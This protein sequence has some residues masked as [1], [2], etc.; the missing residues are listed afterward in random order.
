MTAVIAVRCRSTLPAATY[1][2]ASRCTRVVAGVHRAASN[3]AVADEHD[4]TD[5]GTGAYLSMDKARSLPSD[6]QVS[7]G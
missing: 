6:V 4:D 7:C 1:V 2:E 3:S 5:E